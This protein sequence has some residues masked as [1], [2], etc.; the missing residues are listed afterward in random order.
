MTYPRI[1]LALSLERD[2]QGLLQRVVKLANRWSAVVDVVAVLP[3]DETLDLAAQEAHLAALK[4][5]EFAALQRHMASL[6]IHTGRCDLFCGQV[7]EELIR[8]C[9]QRETSL[10]VLGQHGGDGHFWH[11]HLASKIAARITCDLLV[12]DPER[13]YWPRQPLWLLALPLDETAPMLLEG[14]ATLAREMG[15]RLQLL[16][17]VEP[18]EVA[19]SGLELEYA[20]EGWLADYQERAERQ[21]AAWHLAYG[22]VVQGWQVV[23]GSVTHEL[24]Q[25]AEDPDLALLILGRDERLLSFLVGSPMHGLL[26]HGRGDL[27]IL[28]V[29]ES[30]SASE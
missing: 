18:V 24:S 28:S 27:L 21:L 12:L 4:A 17:V 1:L 7:A 6:S 5:A 20:P 13:S 30:Y 8:R 26:T 25:L 9:N 29:P 3:L 14:A 2:P 11:P 22:D 23:T 15:A 10:L 16:H 19:H